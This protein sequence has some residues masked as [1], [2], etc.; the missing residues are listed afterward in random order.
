LLSLDEG[1]E[2][3]LQGDLPELLYSVGFEKWK[4]RT[5]EAAQRCATPESPPMSSAPGGI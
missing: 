4:V 1:G 5:E 2:I 3:Y